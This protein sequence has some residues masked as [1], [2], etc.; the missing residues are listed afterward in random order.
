[1][2]A[3]IATIGALVGIAVAVLVYLRRRLRPVEPEVLAHGWYIDETVSRIVDGPGEAAFEGTAAFDRV[4]IDGAVNG[5]GTLVQ[6]LGARLRTVQT[7][8]VRHYA[9]GVAIGAVA[10]LIYVVTRIS[11]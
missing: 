9:L 3:V 7:G 4:V 10:L 8:F 2:L 5:T 11:L 6:D 1:V